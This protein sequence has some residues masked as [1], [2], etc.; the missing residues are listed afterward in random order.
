[1]NAENIIKQITQAEALAEQI[2]K[3]ATVQAREILAQANKQALDS[4]L[5]AKAAA[6]KEAKKQLTAARDCA[7]RERDTILLEAEKQA[8]ALRYLT[9]PKMDK[10]VDFIIER[11]IS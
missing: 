11:I 8:E 4:S 5:A 7:N 3:E 10:A 2:V 1:M 6:E 9:K